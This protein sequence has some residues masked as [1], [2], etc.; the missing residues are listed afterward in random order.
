M[1]WTPIIIAGLGVA[2]SILT[3]FISA[4]LTRR[5]TR[6][7]A[8]SLDANAAKTIVEMATQSARD[9]VEDYKAQADEETERR[10]ALAQEFREYREATDRKLAEAMAEIKAQ[11]TALDNLQAK[12]LKL[13]LALQITVGQLRLAGH[14]PMIDP[15]EISTMSIADLRLVAQSTLNIQQRRGK[16]NDDE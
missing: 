13:E 10:R 5:K 16:S 6:A 2:G 3:G 4:W 8:A 1:E 7:E 14:E 12:H 11:E 15:K 9:L